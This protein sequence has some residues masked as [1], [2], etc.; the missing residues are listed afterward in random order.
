MGLLRVSNDFILIIIG[1]IFIIV[2]SAGYLY[3][4]GFT[5][6][7]S[8][9]DALDNYIDVN[10]TA[11]GTYSV[12]NV[13]FNCSD[14]WHVKT[15]NS[16]EDVMIYGYPDEKNVFPFISF[17]PLFYIQIIPNNKIPSKN[18]LSNQDD[19][20]YNESEDVSSDEKI[21]E[22]GYDY[23][24]SDYSGFFQSN[25]TKED[26]KN[27]T[28]VKPNDGRSEQEIIDVMRYSTSEL[29]AIVSNRTIQIDGKAA[30]GDV[31]II[32]SVFPP[33][34]DR[35]L[36]QIVFVKNDK[37]YLITFEAQNWDYEKERMNFDIVLNSFKVN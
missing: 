20:Y 6:T 22:Y 25:S 4:G 24:L 11:N 28:Y 7:S 33:M 36:V 30:Y 1:F 29:G 16:G 27:Y 18:A 17:A 31:F 8:M 32:N 23:A 15:S 3:F 2:L 35:K 26:L 9:N 37:T 14:N 19:I 5:G 34:I 10:K 12:A 13:S 21:S